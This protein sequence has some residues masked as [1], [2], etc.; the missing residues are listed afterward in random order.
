MS[1]YFKEKRDNSCH[2]LGSMRERERERERER[3]LSVTNQ[4]THQRQEKRDMT[5]R[6]DKKESELNARGPTKNQR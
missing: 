1:M 4:C 2:I 5:L 6:Y 3:D